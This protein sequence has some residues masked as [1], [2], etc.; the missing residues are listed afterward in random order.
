MNVQQSL[1]RSCCDDK[2]A[3]LVIAV[4]KRWFPDGCE[5]EWI[6]V[7]TVNEKRLFH[8]VLLFPFEPAVGKNNGPSVLPEWPEHPA[9]GRSFTSG[10]DKS[11]LVPPLRGIPPVNWI[12]LQLRAAFAQQQ[13]PCPGGNVVAAD[14]FRIIRNI[15]FCFFSEKGK[16]LLAGVILRNRPNQFSE[17]ER[18]VIGKFGDAKDQWFSSFMLSA[19]EERR[20]RD[21]TAR[22]ERELDEAIQEAVAEG[23]GIRQ[24]VRE[25]MLRTEREWVVNVP[26]KDIELEK[27]LGGD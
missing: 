11:G 3:F 4:L 26:E 2:E 9:A 21:G 19:D 5:Q 17:L 27:T 14:G 15:P 1:I 24:Q 20:L 12:K 7:L 8:A 23:R 16:V 18:S 25:Q 10:V 22:G 6:S 13:Y